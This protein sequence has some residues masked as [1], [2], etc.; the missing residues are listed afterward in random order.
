[1]L[2]KPCVI[3]RAG[4]KGMAALAD[5]AGPNHSSIRAQFGGVAAADRSTEGSQRIRKCGECSRS[6]SAREYSLRLCGL[7]AGAGDGQRSISC[8]SP[9]RGHVNLSKH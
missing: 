4:N 7:D 5:D 8:S 2:G 9:H 6:E 1:M 3:R